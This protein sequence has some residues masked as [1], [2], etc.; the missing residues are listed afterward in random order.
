MYSIRTS[1]L[2]VGYGIW[3]WD[4][5]KSKACNELLSAHDHSNSVKNLYKVSY[6]LSSEDLRVLVDLKFLLGKNKNKKNKS[7][8]PAE[9]ENRIV[10]SEC[11]L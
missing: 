10:K 1:G 2:F 6:F 9:E 7:C 11:L 8:S 3:L 5:W 4:F